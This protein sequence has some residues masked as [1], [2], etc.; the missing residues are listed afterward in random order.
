MDTGISAAIT[1]AFVRAAVQFLVPLSVD[2][3]PRTTMLLRLYSVRFT[4]L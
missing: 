2:T 1:E 3:R 4:T